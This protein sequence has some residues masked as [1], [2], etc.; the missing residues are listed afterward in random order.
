MQ[1]KPQTP[2]NSGFANINPENLLKAPIACLTGC[3][4]I[5]VLNAL[6]LIFFVLPAFQHREQIRVCFN[7]RKAIARG[8]QAKF[9]SAT[10]LHSNQTSQLPILDAP[11]S[12]SCPEGG[13]FSVKSEGS[14]YIIHC[15]IADHDKYGKTAFAAPHK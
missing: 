14:A 7:H 6:I 11:S 1:G 2:E 15:S 13:K 9:S 10:N 4:G 8:M 3:F 12:L 5:I